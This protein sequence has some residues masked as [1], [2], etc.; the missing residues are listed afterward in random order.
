[1]L[2][3]F[4]NS[5]IFIV[6]IK[7]TGLSNLALKLAQFN[8]KVSGSDVA[9]YFSTQ[10]VLEQNN[11]KIIESFDKS[12]LPPET[13]FLIYSAAYDKESHPQIVLA[14]QKNIPIYSY[15]QFLALLSENF[16]TLAV[17]GTHGKTTSVAALDFLFNEKKANYLALYGSQLL[18][19]TNKLQKELPKF[20]LLEACEYRSHFLNYNLDSLYITTIEHDHPDYFKDEKEVYASF[21][22]LVKKL[23]P[24]TTVVCFGD[25]PNTQ[26]LI[27]TIKNE[28][29]TL[30]LITFGEQE[31]NDYKV[32]DY[33]VEDGQSSFNLEPLKQRFSFNFTSLPLVMDLIGAALFA[34]TNSNSTFEAELSAN[35]SSLKNFK[36]CA[37]RVEFLFEKDQ[38]TYIDDYAHHPN[39]IK[40]SLEHLRNKYK[41]RRIVTIFYPHTYL[42][43]KIF[44]SHFVEALAQSD[45]AVIRG[46]YASARE[47]D[48]VELNDQLAND[49]ASALKSPFIKDKTQLL[50]YLAQ[51]LLPFD[52]C[53]TMGAG[54][55]SDLAYEIAEHKGASNG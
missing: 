2:N 4:K 15:P 28:F 39:E 3:L 32:V 6:G 30:N 49:L 48:E 54:N 22:Q 20:I 16:T 42:R 33:K 23:K 38:I 35:L 1:M 24:K 7:G 50:D 47:K 44:F 25:N 40:T 55:N 34:A 14:A 5:S 27:Q 8:I 21:Y 45:L 53:V 43:T 19:E 12:L 51:S 10:K 31:N 11:I 37:K 9:E 17:A 26:K 46:I 41:N 18:T 29:K 13:N 36:G 52:V